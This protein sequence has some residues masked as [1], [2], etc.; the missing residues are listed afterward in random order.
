MGRY[1]YITYL[2]AVHL[3]QML[4]AADMKPYISYLTPGTLVNGIWFKH[5][6]QPQYFD[7]GLHIAAQHWADLVCATSDGNALRRNQVVYDGHYVSHL[8]FKRFT[9]FI[10]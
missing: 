9:F 1:K 6:A 8:L 10:S 7:Q 5:I 3:L 4:H 2:V